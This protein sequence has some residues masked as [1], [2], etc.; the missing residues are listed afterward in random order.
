MV[1]FKEP[2]LAMYVASGTADKPG[3]CKASRARCRG[4]RT[5]SKR[6][7]AKLD[8]ARK[9]TCFYRSMIVKSH[10]NRIELV[11][12]PAD[13]QFIFGDRFLVAPILTSGQRQRNVYLPKMVKNGSSQEEVD[14]YWKNRNDGRIYGSGEWLRNVKVSYA[15]FKII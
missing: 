9:R 10:Q 5:L 2:R 13:D 7:D 6:T 12:R 4:P 8:C 1:P 3:H 15:A 14:V 11:S